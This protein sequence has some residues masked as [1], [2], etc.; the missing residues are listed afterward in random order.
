VACERG[1]LGYDFASVKDLSVLFQVNNLTDTAFQ[2]AFWARCAQPAP[3]IP[4]PRRP[5]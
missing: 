3:N 2:S 1:R 4:E 5:K